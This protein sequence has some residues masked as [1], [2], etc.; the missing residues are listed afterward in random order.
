MENKPEIVKAM[1]I[2][3]R[4]DRDL[5]PELRMSIAKEQNSL[6]ILLAASLIA[7]AIYNHAI[8]IR[9]VKNNGK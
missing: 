1:E 5:T 9:E 2:F 3:K 8:L 6:S 4:I 7:E